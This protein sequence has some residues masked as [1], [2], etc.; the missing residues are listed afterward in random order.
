[1]RL[2]RQLREQHRDQDLRALAV[3][4]TSG[5]VVG[6]D[7]N[8]RPLTEGMLYN[9]QR[10]TLQAQRLNDLGAQ[11][12][13]KLGYRFAASF[14]LAKMLW[15]QDQG[16]L[17]GVRHFAHQADF[18]LGQLSGQWGMS[19]SSNCLKAGFDLL[20]EDWPDWL[21]QLPEIRSRLPRV[22]APGS[23]VG[24]VDGSVAHE[25]GLPRDLKLVA[26]VT[27]GTAATLASGAAEIGDD[28]TTLGTTLVFKR[29][30]KNLVRDPSGVLYCHRLPGGAWLPGAASNVGANWIREQFPDADLAEMDRRASSLLP[31]QELAYPL[32]GESERFPF[33]AAQAKGF[34]LGSDGDPLAR[35]AAHLQG[36]ALIEKL[37]YETLDRIIGPASKDP[38]PV[39]ATGGASRSDLWTQLRADVTGRVFHR[40][41]HPES[42][43]GSAI[44]AAAGEIFSSHVVAA[45]RGLVRVE[46]TFQPDAKRHDVYDAIY[47]RFKKELE[48]RRYLS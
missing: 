36:T 11:H 9:D 44:L 38:A 21:D 6:V 16:K 17:E 41:R 15:W 12:C 10:A 20:D 45:A 48:A 13:T 33:R 14:A 31:T 8:G 43:F 3:D 19:D 37:A 42:A 2:T 40:P 23:V 22:H 27:D 47:R 26:G 24:V 34:F 5:S 4:G 32:C 30:A 1:V 25:L 18:V 46:R 29:V 28:N 39:Y 7:E 35:Y